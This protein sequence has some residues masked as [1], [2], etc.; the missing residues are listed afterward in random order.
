MP[1]QPA[2]AR[3]PDVQQL[4]YTAHYRCK[5]FNQLA[6]VSGKRR[7]A[8]GGWRMENRYKQNAEHHPA[9]KR[10]K[11]KPS[12][13]NEPARRRPALARALDV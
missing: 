10:S 3:A 2:R 9:S 11:K 6:S 12:K 5:H 8:D 1:R 13:E 4:V 7:A